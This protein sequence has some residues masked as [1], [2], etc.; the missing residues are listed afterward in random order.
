MRI[1]QLPTIL[2]YL[3]VVLSPGCA[4][5]DA[6]DGRIDGGASAVQRAMDV[7]A[8]LFPDLALQTRPRSIEIQGLTRPDSGDSLA[9]FVRSEPAGKWELF[10]RVEGSKVPFISLEADSQ[11]S[12]SITATANASERIEEASRWLAT[13]NGWSTPARKTPSAR[14]GFVQVQFM[15]DVADLRGRDSRTISAYF[16]EN[17]G[18][19]RIVGLPSPP[20]AAEP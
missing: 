12:G 3:A 5:A 11:F 20:P 2:A 14:K 7:A 10:V 13:T 6:P 1:L 4:S 15:I 16:E 19:L 18:R 8:T 9:V 17:T